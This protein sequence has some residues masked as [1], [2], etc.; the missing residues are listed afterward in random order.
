LIS[1]GLRS[2]C[3]KCHNYKTDHYPDQCIE[4]CEDVNIYLKAIGD[5]PHPNPDKLPAY[6]LFPPDKKMQ[7]FGVGKEKQFCSREQ[8]QEFQ[9]VLRAYKAATKKTLKD[10]SV[11]LGTNESFVSRAIGDRDRH[12]E[13][14][15]LTNWRKFLEWKHRLRIKNDF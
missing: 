5:T 15:T 11:E 13:K 12:H 10:I 8:F 6:L 3:P 14:M 1:P 4:S 2:P 9:M 7:Q